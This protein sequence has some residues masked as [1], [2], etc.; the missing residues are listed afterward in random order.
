MTQTISDKKEKEHK[1]ERKDN[2][3]LEIL[4]N[5]FIQL[6]V[7]AIGWIISQFTSEG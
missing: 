3:F 6:P 7:I 2:I 5:I 1:E 4:S